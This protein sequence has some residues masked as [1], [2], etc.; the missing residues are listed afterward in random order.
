MTARLRWLA[1]VQHCRGAVERNT[2]WLR[3]RLGPRIRAQPLRRLLLHAR[4]GSVP[5]QHA[6]AQTLCRSSRVPGAVGVGLIR[7][8]S[9]G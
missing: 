7:A 5:F 1:S 2:Y 6:R 9:R 4:G 8:R 3:S